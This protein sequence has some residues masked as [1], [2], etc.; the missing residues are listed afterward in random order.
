MWED[1]I[2]EWTVLELGKSQRTVEENME[3]LEKNGCK[4]ICGVLM[5]LAVK[6]MLRMDS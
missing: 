5:T 2:W 6:L 4:V 3:Q 1:N